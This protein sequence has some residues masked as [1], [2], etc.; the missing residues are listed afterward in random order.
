MGGFAHSFRGL[1]R[2]FLGILDDAIVAGL[3]KPLLLDGTFAGV[4]RSLKINAKFGHRT[5]FTR[6]KFKL[7]YFILLFPQMP[8]AVSYTPVPQVDGIRLD[9]VCD[10]ELVQVVPV[11]AV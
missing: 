1:F 5:R 6:K 9:M 3:Y 2:L 10:H 4:M 7:D 8:S 11:H